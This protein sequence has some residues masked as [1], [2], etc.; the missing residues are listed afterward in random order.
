MIEKENLEKMLGDYSLRFDTLMVQRM[1]G[2]FNETQ[3]NDIFNTQH[4]PAPLYIY[5]DTLT[6]THTAP[7]RSLLVF[8][9]KTKNL[10]FAC[11]LMKTFYVLLLCF[12]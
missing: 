10:I 11:F 9:Q 8:V 7:E 6:P 3:Q 2:E 4:T 12:Q 1:F 5:I